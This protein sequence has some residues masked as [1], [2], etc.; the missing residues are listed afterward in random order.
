MDVTTPS[1]TQTTPPANVRS[2]RWH[3]VYS[4]PCVHCQREIEIAVA[5]P[6]VCPLCKAVLVIEWRP[7]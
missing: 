5:G 7:Q 3:E 2:V 1:Y 6:H 4:L